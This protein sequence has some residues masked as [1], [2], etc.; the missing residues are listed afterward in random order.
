MFAF[1][2]WIGLHA[3]TV[4]SWLALMTSVVTYAFFRSRLKSVM[5]L[6]GMVV[7]VLYTAIAVFLS[8]MQYLAWTSSEIGLLFLPPHQSW[9]YYLGYVGLRYWL[10]PVFT[11]FIA[12]LWYGFVRLLGSRSERYFNRGEMELTAVIMLAVGWPA[13]LVLLPIAGVVLVL[14]S[15]IRLL[16]FKQSLTTL[17]VP[18]LLAGGIALFAADTLREW[19]GTL[20]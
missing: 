10:A 7:I 13:S 18:F 1:T 15:L 12:G 2:T 6:V 4:I 9:S 20:F 17:A 8:Y 5:A 14:Y 3:V 19:A 16:I 11:L